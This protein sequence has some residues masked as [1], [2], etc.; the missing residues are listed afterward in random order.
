MPGGGRM[1]SMKNGGGSCT[2]DLPMTMV[3]VI[4]KFIG[5]SPTALAFQLNV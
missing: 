2:M 5:G 3:S 1:T 4:G